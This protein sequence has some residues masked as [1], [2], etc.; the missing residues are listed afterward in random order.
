[1]E[2]SSANASFI[3]KLKK[4]RCQEDLNEQRIKFHN[5]DKVK[6]YAAASNQTQTN[7][8]QINY[9]NFLSARTKEVKDPKNKKFEAHFPL[10]P[11]NYYS[12]N[13]LS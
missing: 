12:K 13:Y 10:Y 9:S 6:K 11:N 4:K 7:L 1:M 5:F 8:E 3:K 2:E